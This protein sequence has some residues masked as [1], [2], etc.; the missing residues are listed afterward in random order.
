MAQ[1]VSQAAD[2]ATLLAEREILRTMHQYSLAVDYSIEDRWVDCF[3]E[4]GVYEV[5]FP[6]LPEKQKTMRSDLRGREALQRFA[7]AR[8]EGMR[9]EKR[10][11]FQKHLPLVPLIDVHGDEATVVSH[12]VGLDREDGLPVVRDIGRYDDTFVRCEDGRWRIKRRHFTGQ[13]YRQHPE[14]R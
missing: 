10:A 9:A 5:D 12:F 14:N 13:G 8:A 7:A 2:L 3:T 11:V 4:D 6:E 1:D